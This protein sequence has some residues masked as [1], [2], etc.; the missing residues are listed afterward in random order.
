MV[1]VA[2]LAM[3]NPDDPISAPTAMPPHI[4]D[5]KFG[6]APGPGGNNDHDDAHGEAHTPIELCNLNTPRASVYEGAADGNNTS[7][8]GGLQDV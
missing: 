8:A 7:S 5:L 1:L 3:R 6:S 4:S 2:W